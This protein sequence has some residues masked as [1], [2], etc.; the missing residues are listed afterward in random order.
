[1]AWYVIGETTTGKR[2]IVRAVES[3]KAAVQLMERIV[4]GEHDYARLYARD[5]RDRWRVY[6]HGEPLQK[7][8]GKQRQGSLSEVVVG[9]L[10][11][12][13]MRLVDL[14]TA[15]LQADQR[16]GPAVM[17]GHRVAGLL[18]R[19]KE[20]KLVSNYNGVWSLVK[21]VGDGSR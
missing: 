9:L 5:A 18:S 12:G 15:A 8:K 2:T 6:G 4:E 21:G 14:A 17:A 19:L 11:N 16:F 7:R 1:M 10:Q 3:R 13:G 20:R